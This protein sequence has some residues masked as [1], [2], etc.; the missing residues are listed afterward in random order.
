[1]AAGDNPLYNIKPRSGELG[2]PTKYEKQTYVVDH[3]MYPDDLMSPVNNQYGGNYVIFYINVHEDSALYKE[4]EAAKNIVEDVPPNLQGEVSGKFNTAEVMAAVSIYGGITGAARGAR[5]GGIGGVRVSDVVRGITGIDPAMYPGGAQI[6]N[7]VGGA[8]LGGA[9]GAAKGLALSG[10]A[11]VALGGV[12]KKFKRLRTAVALHVPTD[13]GINYSVDW[14]STTDIAGLTAAATMGESLGN[15]AVELAKTNVGQSFTDLGNAGGAGINYLISKG[16]QTS[17]LGE[18]ISKTSGTAANPKKEQLFRN[19]D[20]RTFSFNYQFFPRS[21][22]E[23]KKVREIIKMFKLHMHPEFKDAS[24]FLYTYPSEFDIYY[25][26]DT[27]ENMNLHRHTSCV[28]TDMSVS[29]TPQGMLSTFD[30][31]MPTQINVSLVFKE[32][33]LLT[34][35][36]ILDGY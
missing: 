30:D 16:L 25:Y 3:L 18:F 33:A 8:A 23:A 4:A 1:M 34:K 14:S 19:V 20:F 32:L 22:E 24:H 10:L 7:K 21:K 12:S 5:R 31:G 13:L 11:A 36:A 27:V 15:S 26:Q 17:G 35:E 28:L 6:V 9:A 29:Y 2:T